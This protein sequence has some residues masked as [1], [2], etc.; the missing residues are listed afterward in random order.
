M[1][2]FGAILKRTIKEA[3][4]TQS[5]FADKTNI[6]LSSLKKYMSNKNLPDIDTLKIICNELNCSYDYLL[7]YSKVPEREHSD[8]RTQS[9]LSVN[10]ADKLIKCAESYDTNE[11]C[12]K[13]IDTISTIIETGTLGYLSMMVADKNSVKQ[14]LNLLITLMSQSNNSSF[15]NELTS[16][17][18]SD[19]ALDSM[20]MVGLIQNLN[21]DKN[22]YKEH[23]APSNK[24]KK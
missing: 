20:I 10:A 17:L 12:R 6:G 23:F 3:G 8:F 13:I 15:A 7:G 14:E 16:G 21:L 24:A 1:D 19:T 4:Y 11:G 5:E 18:N 22:Y 9:R 2:T